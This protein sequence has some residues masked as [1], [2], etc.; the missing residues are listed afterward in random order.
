MHFTPAAT[1]ILLLLGGVPLFT[2]SGILA[3]STWN[4]F[5]KFARI[6]LYVAWATFVWSMIG[7]F[8]FTRVVF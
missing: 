4:K 6:M 8:L 7:I 2:I 1:T 3:W 5:N